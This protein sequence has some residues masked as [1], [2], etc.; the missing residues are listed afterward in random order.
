MI[1]FTLFPLSSFLYSSNLMLLGSLPSQ[2]G[3]YEQ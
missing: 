3:N 1:T 2:L